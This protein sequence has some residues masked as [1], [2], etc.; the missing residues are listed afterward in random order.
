MKY[1]LWIALGLL[2]CHYYAK[3][4]DKP[5]D[6]APV[7]Q[8][9]ELSLD[10]KNFAMLNDKAR[11]P[12]IYPEHPKEGIN[13]D[14]NLGFLWNVGYLNSSIQS[15]TTESQYRSIGLELH[16]GVHVGRYLDFGGYHHSEHVLDE[17]QPVYSSYPSE[18][19]V[20]IRLFLYRR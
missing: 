15:L 3:A 5:Y 18:D 9:N 16:Y 17:V 19:A 11:N 13:V 12:Y 1:F 10:Y 20:E 7:F 6:S 8:L 14:M 4:S 2:L